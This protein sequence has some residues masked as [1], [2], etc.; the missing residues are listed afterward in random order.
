MSLTIPGSA[1]PGFRQPL[2][3]PV[4]AI[5]EPD[6]VSGNRIEDQSASLVA[7]FL[8]F[9]MQAIDDG[10][11]MGSPDMVF[12]ALLFEQPQALSDIRQ[13]AGSLHPILARGHM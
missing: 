13:F 4:E 6:Q 7:Q 8:V 5:I 1:P 2:R 10:F 3:I 9:L 12:S 11:P